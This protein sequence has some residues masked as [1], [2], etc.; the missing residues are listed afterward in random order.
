MRV[1]GRMI[2][3]LCYQPGN[4]SRTVLS[5]DNFASWNFLRDTASVLRAGRALHRLGKIVSNFLPVLAVLLW[6]S[7]S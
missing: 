3:L 6:S 7:T 2:R 1:A 5:A 4:V